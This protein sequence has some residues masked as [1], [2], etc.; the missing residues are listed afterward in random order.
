MDLK[1]KLC[2]GSEF[3]PSERAWPPSVP[4][5]PKEYS[6]RGP[7]VEPEASYWSIRPC[8]VPCVVRMEDLIR[9]TDDPDHQCYLPPYPVDPKVLADEI[10]ELNEL[11]SLRDDPSALMYPVPGNPLPTGLVGPGEPV[12]GNR[13]RLAISPFL[14]LRPQPLGAVFT[15]DRTGNEP[16]IRTGRELARW[17][18]S[19]TPGLGHRQALNDLLTTANWSP[20]RQALVWMALDVAIYSSLLAAW[21]YK[22]FTRRK[23]VRYRLRPVEYDYRV[24]VLYNHKVN[25]TGSGDGDRRLTPDPS[26]GT[27]RHPAYPSGHSTIGGA[28]SEILS[29][30]FPDYT[31]EFDQLADNSGMARLWAGIH[32]RSDHE[33]GVKLGRCV[34]RMILGK[35]QEGCICPPNVC[36]TPEP[37]GKPPSYGDVVKSARAFSDCCRRKKEYETDE[38][39]SSE[40]DASEQLEE[41]ESSLGRGVSSEALREQARGPQEGST[42][43]GSQRGLREQARSPQK[44][45]RIGRSQELEEEQAEGPQ[46]GGK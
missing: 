31:A 15:R 25:A 37:C 42:P 18:E 3:G 27:P 33:Q 44:G 5:K 12:I 32:W 8:P 17:F 4:P 13:R 36:G 29:F 19:E 16:V 2:T 39:A 23:D 9:I 11:A 14:Q 40:E 10:A 30:F 34:A 26:P 38:P 28:G 1:P 35:L 41:G 7:Q 24:S 46:E 45:A 43:A 21:H 6:L 20:P 22:W